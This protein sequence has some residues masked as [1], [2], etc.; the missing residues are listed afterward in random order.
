MFL[1]PHLQTE[2]RRYPVLLCVICL[3]WWWL[4]MRIDFGILGSRHYRRPKLWA[5]LLAVMAAALLYAGA[6]VIADGVHQWLSYGSVHPLLFATTACLTLW[7]FALAGG[8]ISATLRLWHGKFPSPTESRPRRPVLAYGFALIALVA[9]T[10]SLIGYVRQVKVDPESCAA[11]T[12][13]GCIHGTVADNGGK[14]LKGIEVEVL[15]A[16]KTGETRW[17][18]KKG[19]W[20]DAKGRFSVDQIEPGKYLVAVHYY[21]APDVR[22]PFATT[23]YPG[24]EA[25]DTATRVLVVPNSPT[26]LKQLR[27]RALPLATI[28]VEVIWPDGT[29]PQRSSL[30]FH[31]RSYPSQGGDR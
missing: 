30:S 15:P 14:P 22:Q 12:N 21:G 16:D 7:S 1:L 24:L 18:S 26:M 13:R 6:R 11:S 31:N 28:K 5:I 3:W 25:E 27:L 23:F 9:A 2:M 29:S 17:Y 8:C 20:T 4:G 19:E 10:T